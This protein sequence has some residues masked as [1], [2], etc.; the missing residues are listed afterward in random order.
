M[1][2]GVRI[3]G[4]EGED[5]DTM[6]AEADAWPKV[7][8]RQ[9]ISQ[10]ARERVQERAGRVAPPF[11]ADGARACRCAER[12]GWLEARLLSRQRRAL[13]ELEP[14]QGLPMLAAV[15]G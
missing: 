12:G 4:S 13:P 5:E 10:T 3:S 14:P 11:A 6:A 15:R 1:P 9:P 2:C 8:T 7:K